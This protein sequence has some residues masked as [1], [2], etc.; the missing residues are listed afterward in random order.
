[1]ISDICMEDLT[2]AIN[3]L[4]QGCGFVEV[5]LEEEE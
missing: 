3:L 1:M 5:H 2:P 4:K